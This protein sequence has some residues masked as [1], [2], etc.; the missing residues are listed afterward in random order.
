[1]TWDSE[2]KLCEQTM[3]NT[4]DDDFAQRQGSAAPKGV[5][6][7]LYAVNQPHI[8]VQVLA[9]K[10]RRSERRCRVSG[11]DYLFGSQGEITVTQDINIKLRTCRF[12]EP[13]ASFLRAGVVTQD[14]GFDNTLLICAGSRFKRWTTFLPYLRASR[15]ATSATALCAIA[16]DSLRGQSMLGT[17]V[18][19]MGL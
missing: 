14:S 17:I 7:V 2:N 4:T 15:S 6:T 16:E 13:L 19:N 8:Q 12:S 10:L 1:M 9:P 5:A 3:L 11:C 18:K